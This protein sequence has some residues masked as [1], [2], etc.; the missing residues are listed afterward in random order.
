MAAFCADVSS[1]VSLLRDARVAS[2]RGSAMSAGVRSGNEEKNRVAGLLAAGLVCHPAAA[3]HILQSADQ[4]SSGGCRRRCCRVC[5]TCVLLG[6]CY[7]RDSN[8]HDIFR[9]AAALSVRRQQQI[10]AVAVF[11]AAPADALFYSVLTTLFLH[12]RRSR[13]ARERP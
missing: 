11:S 2:Q 10:A 8:T 5:Q 7:R 13:F 3:R 6:C 9:P 1:V 4:Y 12:R